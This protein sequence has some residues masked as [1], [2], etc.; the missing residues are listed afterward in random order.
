MLLLPSRQRLA[1]LLDAAAAVV[2]TVGVGVVRAHHDR[3]SVI[4]ADRNGLGEYDL[5]ASDAPPLLRPSNDGPRQAKVSAID[6]NPDGPVAWLLE[7]SGVQGLVS[8]DVPRLPHISQVL[9]RGEPST[10]L[11][12]GI[13]DSN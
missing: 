8:L 13:S 12:I 11:W 7:R 10:R 9:Q 1:T 4:Y 5:S 3:M 2:P 6:A